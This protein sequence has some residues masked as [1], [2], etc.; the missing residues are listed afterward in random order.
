MTFGILFFVVLSNATSA[1]RKHYFLSF[2]LVWLVLGNL[3]AGFFISA[4]PAFYGKVTG[5][6]IRFGEQLLMLSQ[7]EN[8]IAIRAQEYLWNLYEGGFTGFGAGISAFPS[9]HVGVT[10]INMLFAFEINRKL[11]IIALVYFVFVL[12]SSVFLAWHYLVDGL[13]SLLI[14]V[15]IYYSTK[16]IIRKPATLTVS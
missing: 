15:A 6:E 1:I 11:G 8:S 7:F 12:W 3:F 16:L 14:V 4:G 10:V 2:T 9:V 5:D 13:A